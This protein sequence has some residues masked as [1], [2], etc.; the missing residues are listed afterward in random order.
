MSNENST[1]SINPTRGCDRKSCTGGAAIDQQGQDQRKLF[2]T[3]LEALPAQPGFV[4]WRGDGDGL[5]IV[6]Y[7]CRIF[8]DQRYL[9][10]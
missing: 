3:G 6:G 4:S 8:C 10:V 2:S 1:I 5:T 7:L 9:P